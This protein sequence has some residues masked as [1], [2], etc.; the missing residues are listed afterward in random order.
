MGQFKKVG[1]LHP[2][3]MGVSI[4]QALADSGHDVLWVPEGRSADTQARAA[5][6]TGVS[7]LEEMAAQA[8][9]IFSICPPHAALA[10]AEAVA[11]TGYKG[12]YVDANAVSPQTAQNV[13][14]FVGANYVDGG[15]IGPPAT[16]PGSTRMYVSGELSEQVVELFSA[17]S[18]EVISIGEGT[19]R[20]STLKMA[21]AA[22]TKGSSA[23][24]LAVNALAEAGG[25][26]EALNQEWA[27]SQQGL[28]QR[29]EGTAKGT[30]RKAWRFVGEM[31]EIAATFDSF[32]LPGDFHKGAAEVYARMSALKDVP[33]SELDDVIAYLLKREK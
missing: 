28:G 33:P 12:V 10:Q 17:G 13:A 32:E 6:F 9:Y 4:C 20:A 25:V 24:L 22:Y 11:A 23:L 18:L 31:E 27:I 7:S 16:Q 3:E 8:D 21:Y 19:T 15:V 30:S 5:A 1:V 2:G 29:S 14:S 26:R